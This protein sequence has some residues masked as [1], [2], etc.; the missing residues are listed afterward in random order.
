MSRGNIKTLLDGTE[1]VLRLLAAGDT[2]KLHAFFMTLSDKARQFLYD[3]VTD[4]NIVEQWTKEANYDHV[5]PIVAIVNDE[6]VADGTLHKRNNGP[7]RHIGR[8][9]VVVREDYLGKGLGTIITNELTNIA[10]ARKLSCLY[11][12]L[13]EKSEADAIEAVEKQGFLRAS[14]LPDFLMDLNGNLENAVV[15]VKNI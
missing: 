2:D 5:V 9:R 6:I 14:V 3:D 4:V 1:V 8:I 11:V 13:A 10:K 12:T 15:F 7:S